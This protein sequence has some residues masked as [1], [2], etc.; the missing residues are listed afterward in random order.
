MAVS[1]GFTGYH[2]LRWLLCLVLL[3]IAALPSAPWLVSMAEA[4]RGVTQLPGSTARDSS[5]LQASAQR[6]PT[7]S[8]APAPRIPAPEQGLPSAEMLP[9]TA[10]GRI[11]PKDGVLIIAAP[12]SLELGPAIVTEMHV[13]QGDW[14]EAGQRLVTLRGYEQL[15]AAHAASRR[16]VAIARARLIA[17]K[18]G[19]KQDDIRALRAE[20]Q[21]DEATLAQAEA[22]TH[23]M[24]QLRDA[25]IVPVAA[26]E[27]Q[28]SRLTVALRSLEAKRARLSGLSTV[29]PA[30]IS[31]AEAELDAA[32][33]DAEE[34]RTKLEQTIVRAP[35]AGRVLAA[36]AHPGQSVGADGV[37]AFGRTA[38]M[39][40]DAEVAEE[41]IRRARVG[42][43][44]QITGDVLNGPVKGV[45]EEVGY[46]VGSREVFNT[47]P[48]AF[49]DS[50]IVHVKIRITDVKDLERFIDARVT[51]E[52]RQ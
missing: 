21:S 14:V 30:D 40:V 43:K 13:H 47:D 27:S 41:D 25:R 11:Q 17:L 51:V 49:A 26:L 1:T 48:T 50:R 9:V 8:Q 37:L 39:Y 45:V 6:D 19:A 31:V 4:H 52:I 34:A 15:E 20:V 33:A 7:Q 5:R 38:E 3:S 32:Q 42:Q 2:R 22:D 46:I 24:K 18:S 44:A 12:S 28:E 36:F 16:K 35:T 29:R 10:Q 23:R